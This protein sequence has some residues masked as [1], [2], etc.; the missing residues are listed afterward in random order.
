LDEKD[1]IVIQLSNETVNVVV[2]GSILVVV[3]RPSGKDT[4]KF[5]DQGH[6]GNIKKLYRIVDRE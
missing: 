3:K 5:Q 1:E 2:G 4:D 6:V